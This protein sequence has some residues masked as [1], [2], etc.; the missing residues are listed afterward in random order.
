MEHV[1]CYLFHRKNST[2]GIRLAT[3]LDWPHGSEGTTAPE[4]GVVVRWGNRLP[5]PAA[6]PAR[7]Y[8]KPEAIRLAA[9][10]L[11]AL[12]AM[13]EAGVPALRILDFDEPELPCLGRTRAHERGSGFF[14]C[15]TREQVTE[16]KRQG[17]E[18][19]VPLLDG[20][21]EYRVHVFL[22]R[23][24]RTVF[25]RSATDWERTSIQTEAEAIALRVAACLGLDIAAVD[26]IKHNNTWYVLEANTAPDVDAGDLKAW[27]QALRDLQEY[28]TADRAASRLAAT[29]PK[30]R[31]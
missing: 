5:Y 2:A 20:F 14:P 18:Y 4:D 25:K 17:A 23:V 9:N 29:Y 13:H 26:L 24:L 30:L 21:R 8:N 15:Q 19:F 7:E 22:G 6:T 3:A 31:V 27:V 28:H 12:E 10:K 11:A 1:T 16:A